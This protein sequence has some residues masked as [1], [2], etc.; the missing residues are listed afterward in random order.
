MSEFPGSIFSP[1]TCMVIA[2]EISQGAL[3]I[4]K[5]SG[6]ALWTPTKSMTPAVYPLKAI[7][8]RIT[9]Y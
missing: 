2:T 5:I 1:E 3:Q 4:T 8:L 9:G 6:K 7:S